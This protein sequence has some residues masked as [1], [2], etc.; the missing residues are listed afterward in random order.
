MLFGSSL[1]AVGRGYVGKLEIKF[2]GTS[3]HGV[4]DP[5]IISCLMSIWSLPVPVLDAL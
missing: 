4:L 2:A 1:D 3:A 5:L